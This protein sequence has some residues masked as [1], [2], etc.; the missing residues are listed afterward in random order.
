[1]IRPG[2]RLSQNWKRSCRP[3]PDTFFDTLHQLVHITEIFS[4]GNLLRTT[5]PEEKPPH[6]YWFVAGGAVA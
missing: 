4:A 3:S 1:M 2:G 5:R 6:F